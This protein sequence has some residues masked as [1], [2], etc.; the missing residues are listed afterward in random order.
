MIVVLIHCNDDADDCCDNANGCRCCDNGCSGGKADA[1]L[2]LAD[3]DA[4]ARHMLMVILM[5]VLMLML[6]CCH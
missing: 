6:N 2:F 4:G 5:A 1:A 3:A